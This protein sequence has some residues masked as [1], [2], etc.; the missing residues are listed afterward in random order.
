MHD[1]TCF[2]ISVIVLLQKLFARR[3]FELLMSVSNPF[4]QGAGNEAIP[5]QGTK[6]L[7]YTS[8]HNVFDNSYNGKWQS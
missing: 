6:R 1:S 7:L 3:P 2:R 8:L 5:R 4:A